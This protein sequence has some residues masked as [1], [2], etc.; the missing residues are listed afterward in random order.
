MKP[1][2]IALIVL[3][4]M[5]WVCSIGYLYAS[6]GIKTKPGYVKLVLPNPELVSP[7]ISVTLGPSGVGPVRWLFKRLASSS[8]REL[9]VPER[10]LSSV[11]Q[12]LRGVQLSVYEVDNN[13]AVFD[14]A[15]SSSLQDLR[16]Q[17]WQTLIK[18]KEDHEHVLIMQSSNGA[19]I[20]GI[21]LLV[22]SSDNAVFVNLVG[23][24]DAD[25][26]AAA[27]EL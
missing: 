19:E 17:G 5:V 9:D 27:A 12:D 6:S 8:N 2:Q 26:V 18:V 1:I 7:Q 22:N 13:R 4:S 21:S 25:E 20:S 3:L 16:A 24:F 15:I 14:E 10:V 11:L 23:P